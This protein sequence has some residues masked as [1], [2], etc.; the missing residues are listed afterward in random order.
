MLGDEV[1]RFDQVPELGLS[2]EV[3]ERQPEE[4]RPE[5]AGAGHRRALERRGPLGIDS[6]QAVDVRRRAEAS[7]ARLDPEEVV[8][9]GDD[10]ARVQHRVG[11]PGQRVTD[12]QREDSHAVELRVA[13]DLEARIGR[14]GGERPPDEPAL[15]L[16]DRFR[17]DLLPQGKD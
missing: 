10:E 8:E 2:R 4:S 17:A 7:A 5:A 6:G 16:R 9:E 1:D 11:A 15:E 13:R 12:T 3:G 14:P